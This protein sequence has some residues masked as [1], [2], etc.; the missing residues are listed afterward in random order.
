VADSDRAAPELRIVALLDRRIERVHVDM[1]DLAQ[2]HAAT[3]TGPE[4][5]EN[6]DRSG[7]AVPSWWPQTFGLLLDEIESVSPKARASRVA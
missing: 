6:P 3:L 2:R 7:D 5:K 4:W 1:D